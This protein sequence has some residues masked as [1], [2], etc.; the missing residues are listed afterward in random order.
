MVAAAIFFVVGGLGPLSTW[1]ILPLEDRFPRAV[2]GDRPVDGI[3][4]L[5]GSED[6][7]VAKG[8]GTHAL[9]ELAE[10]LTEAAT[11]ARRYPNCQDPIHRRER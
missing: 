6:A 10:R 5:G 8:R 4:I 9:N 2:L 3:V 11:L 7:R 1:M